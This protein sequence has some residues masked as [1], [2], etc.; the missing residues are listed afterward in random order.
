MCAV[1]VVVV[2][3]VVVVVV[4]VDS[5]FNRLNSIKIMNKPGLIEQMQ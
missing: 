5:H 2:G 1:V 4:V 3:V